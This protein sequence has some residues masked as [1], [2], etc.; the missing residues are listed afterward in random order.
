MNLDELDNYLDPALT[1]WGNTISQGGLNLSQTTPRCQ[2]VS[3][4]PTP[5]PT[6]EA[7]QSRTESA[8]PVDYDEIVCYGLVNSQTVQFPGLG[9]SSLTPCPR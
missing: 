7:S 5:S 4:S 3:H 2:E 6:P 8:S 1:E 9:S